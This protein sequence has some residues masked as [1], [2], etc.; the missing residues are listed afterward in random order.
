MS[1]GQ[2]WIAAAL[3]ALVIAFPLTAASYRVTEALDVLRQRV[4]RQRG[5]DAQT[6]GEPT[7]EQVEAGYGP[8]AWMAEDVKESWNRFFDS[9]LGERCRCGVRVFPRDLDDHVCR[10]AR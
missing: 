7:R 4:R 2:F 8:P 6:F 10:S 3:V 9:L 1:D 5:R